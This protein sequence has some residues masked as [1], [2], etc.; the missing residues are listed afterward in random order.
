[1]ISM[2]TSIGSA[3]TLSSAS[4]SNSGTN[5][6]WKLSIESFSS[7][8]SKSSMS[9]TP[10]RAL[11]PSNRDTSSCRN[12]FRLCCTKIA[13]ARLLRLILRLL[14]WS[15]VSENN[16]FTSRRLRSL[17]ALLMV[18]MASSGSEIPS[19]SLRSCPSVFDKMCAMIFRDRS[20][21]LTSGSLLSPPPLL[22]R[23]DDW[24]FGL[25]CCRLPPLL[26]SMTLASRSSVSSVSLSLMGH[27]T[28]LAA[29]V[30]TRATEHRFSH[31]ASFPSPE[32]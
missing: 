26:A 31:R 12:F 9:S 19:S 22:T 30:A 17:N 6:L 21:T 2:E 14:T 24:T 10:R 20:Y 1:M 28:C 29:R 27:K 16:F 8:H 7:N 23:A 11:H 5:M 25:C 13:R 3:D 18:E 32:R 4:S 15:T